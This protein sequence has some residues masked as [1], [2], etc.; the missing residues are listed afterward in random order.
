M[1]ISL[2]FRG[3][4]L[5]PAALDRQL[6][7]KANRTWRTGDA[8][9][10]TARRRRNSGWAYRIGPEE[11]STFEKQ[12]V[13]LEEILRSRVSKLRDLTSNPGFEAELCLEAVIHESRPYAA[14]SPGLLGLL[15]DSGIELCVDFFCAGSPE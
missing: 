10:G 1:A 13:A 14:V 9:P 4:S 15:A 2:T 3:D 11:V 12:L 5:D 6:G 8:I 7:L